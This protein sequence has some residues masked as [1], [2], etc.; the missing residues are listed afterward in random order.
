M[1]QYFL[2]GGI[3]NDTYLPLIIV[4]IFISIKN[5]KSAYQVDKVHTSWFAYRNIW[6]SFNG[7]LGL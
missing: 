2:S 3:F 4:L 1:I 7:E 6:H 5:L